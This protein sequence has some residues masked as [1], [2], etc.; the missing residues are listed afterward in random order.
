VAD[1]DA[2]ATR[3]NRIVADLL[4]LTRSERGALDTSGEPVLVHRVVR[5]VV[6]REQEAW[7]D[8]HIVMTIP[9][10]LAPVE[11]EPTYV[12]Q[13]V[14][15]LLSN[16]LK[17]GR[18]P[19]AP[20]EVTVVRNGD[21]AEVRVL[22]RGVGFAPGETDRL[23]TLFYRNP[24]AVGAAPGA[25]IGLYVCRLLAE[26]MNG[27]AWA[28]PRPGGGAEFGFALPLMKIPTGPGAGIAAGRGASAHG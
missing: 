9:D 17:Y 8:A 24:K 18:S 23:F 7:P 6:E 12:E 21:L 11:A 20:I 3:L 4:V 10:E 14:R 27:T 5:D 26:A 16:A 22:D 2:D 28:R 1:I 25:G 15:N 13:I 19:S